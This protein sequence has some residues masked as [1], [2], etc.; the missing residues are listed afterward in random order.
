M[1][2]HVDYASFRDPSGYVLHREGRVLRAV[3]SRGAP[4]YAAA[5]EGGLV[6]EL[7]ERGWLVATKRL[8]PPTD[9]PALGDASI[10][11]EHERLP[12]ISYPYEWTFS[13][14]RAA[15]LLHLDIHLAA[16][17]R[18]F[19][20][21]DSTAYNVQFRGARPIFIDVLS[22]R[23]YRDGAYWDG[24]RQFCQQFLNPL[25]LQAYAG[26][27]FNPW[28]RGAITGISAAELRP[29]LPLRRRLSPRVVKHVTLNAALSAKAAATSV[30]KEM[31]TLL[32]AGL[33]LA[34][35]RNLIGSMRAWIAELSWRAGGATTWSDY[36]TTRLYLDEAL[37]AKQAFVRD[38]V[39]TTR[40]RLL[41]DLGCNAGEFAFLAHDAG[42]A[43]V[44]GWD[45]DRGA[46][47]ECFARA[48]RDGR[49]VTPLIGDLMNPSPSQGWAECER[50]GWRARAPADAALAL[51]IVHHLAIANNV[52][53]ASIV[54]WLLS[55][56]PCGVV[57][58]VS[59]EDPQVR[60]MLSAREDIFPDYALA[61]FRELLARKARIVRFADL[62]GGTRHIFWY[63]AGS[64]R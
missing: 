46:I 8:D 13:A 32:R 44:V 48:A 5:E 10:L 50:G 61:A 11:L 7:I 52:P 12:F 55:L 47:E 58:F 62:P 9:D 60:R 17:A 27:P 25:L 29:T 16:L 30:E 6:A 37:A 28:Y 19:T 43:Y 2:A 56:A 34:A 38:F 41:W 51:A 63:D 21:S 3:T 26:I 42:A 20:L 18:G 31:P 22:F 23:R 15:A 57:E 1:S 4:D 33:P 24:Y 35:L 53:L 59:K 40:P 54:D 64:F 14:L 39:A 49:P 45:S 36:E